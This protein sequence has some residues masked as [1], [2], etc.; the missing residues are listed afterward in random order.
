V[1]SGWE[2]RIFR[3]PATP[4]ETT[5]TVV[6]LANFPLPS[7]IGDYGDG[8]VEL[9]GPL[10][11]LA[12]LVEFHPDQ[13]SDALFGAP[14]PPRD[15]PVEEFRRTTLQHARPGHLGAQRFFNAAGR[16][17]SLFVVLGSEEL[18]VRLVGTLNSAL[19]TLQIGAHE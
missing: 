9:M 5:H 8:A 7:E 11:I 18:R 1:P 4:P 6:Q 17:W 13:A 12:C 15:L 2:A 16:A 3:R 14:G 19:R 10:S